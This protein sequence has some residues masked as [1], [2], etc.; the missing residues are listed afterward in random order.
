MAQKIITKQIEK[1]FEK[2]PL[3]SQENVKDP[4]VLVKIFNPYGSGTWYITE[5]EKQDDGDY[6]CF[7]LVRLHDT[8]LGYFMLSDLLNTRINVY[9]CPLPLERDMYFKGTLNDAYNECGIKREEAA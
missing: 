4:K 2:Y 8:E 7:G 3:Y 6:L 5:V 9:G 1:L